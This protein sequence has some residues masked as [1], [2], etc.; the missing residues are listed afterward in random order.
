MITI[1]TVKQLALA[2]AQ[3]PSADNSQPWHF[4][5]DGSLFSIR[6]DFERVMGHTFPANSSATLL[7]LGAT[8]ENIVELSKYFG[9]TTNVSWD[10]HSLSPNHAEASIHFQALDNSAPETTNGDHPVFHRHTNRFAFH[11]TAIPAPVVETITS[12]SENSARLLV[13]NQQK[14]IHD[15]AQLV[16]SASEIRFQI[17][18]VH[19]WLGKSLRFSPEDVKKADG[20]DVK[21]IDLPP[22]GALFLRFICSWKRMNL[23][24]RIGGYKFLAQMDS[25]PIKAAP[26]I[27]AIIAPPTAQGAVDAGKLM[28]RAWTYLNT[29]GI[30]VHPYYVVADQLARLEEGSLPQRFIKQAQQL[31]EGCANHLSLNS[32]ETL[33]MLLRV[34]YPTRTPPRSLRLE[35]EVIFRDESSHQSAS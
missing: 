33:H 20:L 12:L 4:N 16:K 8:I 6:Y 26:T 7:S 9:F 17:K 15:V 11:K 34:G 29:Q 25:A 1:E 10:K 14:L 22:G 28:C 21:T 30:A 13:I 2:G 5:W 24:N 19:E 18:E 3:A 32:E 27:I 35:R 31:K 23:L